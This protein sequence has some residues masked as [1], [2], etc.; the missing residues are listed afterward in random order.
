MWWLRL[1]W[2]TCL[3]LYDLPKVSYGIFKFSR[4][5]S[6]GAWRKI[7]LASYAS[8]FENENFFWWLLR[9]WT[10]HWYK[11]ILVTNFFTDGPIYRLICPYYWGCRYLNSDQVHWCASVDGLSVSRAIYRW[12]YLY[13]H[14]QSHILF[15]KLMC[16]SALVQQ[17]IGFL[18]S[19]LWATHSLTLKRDGPY[20]WRLISRLHWVNI[21]HSMYGYIQAPRNSVY[22]FAIN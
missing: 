18:T 12:V 13:I 10:T 11:K 4:W 14:D 16:L 20:I 17:D 3:T 7:A 9:P 19:R 21:W 6:S 8:H 22:I 15:K 5:G 2:C 1:F